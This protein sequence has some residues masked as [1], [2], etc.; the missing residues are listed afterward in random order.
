MRSRAHGAKLMRHKHLPL[1]YRRVVHTMTPTIYFGCVCARLFF[2][3][4]III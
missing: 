1:A 3:I 2:E 4:I